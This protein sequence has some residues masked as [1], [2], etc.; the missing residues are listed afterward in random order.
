MLLPLLDRPVNN[1]PRETEGTYARIAVRTPQLFQ[2]NA[3]LGTTNAYGR[4]P[5]Q[6]FPRRRTLVRGR[7]PYVIILSEKLPA[8]SD[9][10]GCRRRNY[11]NHRSIGK[12]GR[13]KLGLR[14]V[15]S[16]RMVGS[17]RRHRLEPTP[18][19]RKPAH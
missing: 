15:A 13:T 17:R 14:R 2:N 1:V 12:E 4:G 16:Q 8:A 18:G 11:Q 6:G 10:L 9:H 3:R 5:V 7:K 19:R